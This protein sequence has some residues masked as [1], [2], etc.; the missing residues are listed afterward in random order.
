M[1]IFVYE[2]YHL[3][4]SG[5]SG[6]GSTGDQTQQDNDQQQQDNQEQQPQQPLQPQ[7]PNGGSTDQEPNQDGQS[8]ERQSDSSD[9]NQQPQQPQQPDSGDTNQQPQQPQQPDSGDTNQQPQQPQQP[10][11]GDQQ[12]DSNSGLNGLA[13]G[14]TTAQPS[15][16]G[17]IARAEACMES[18]KTFDLFFVIYSILSYCNLFVFGNHYRNRYTDNFSL[19]TNIK[20]AKLPCSSC[21]LRD[22]EMDF[23]IKN[24]PLVLFHQI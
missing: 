11:S 2:K 20:S 10:D 24:I 8:G 22:M 14:F 23:C 15:T 9:T 17:E 12:P 19:R 1:L 18:G 6:S 4:T 7:Q 5:S 3:V 13:P 21:W 16:D